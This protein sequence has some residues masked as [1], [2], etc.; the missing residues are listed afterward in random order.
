MNAL[1][2]LLARLLRDPR[3][4]AALA[5]AQGDPTL[6]ADLR[7]AL[8]A[9]DPEG[10]TVHALLVAQWR[11]ARIRRGDPAV[12]AAFEADPA[13]FIDTFR[14]YHAAVPPLH[15]HPREEARAFRRSRSGD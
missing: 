10:F 2:A 7:A 11:F 13:A 1:E 6:P 14:A 8:A 12:E 9:I 15:W 5:A 3:P 4:A